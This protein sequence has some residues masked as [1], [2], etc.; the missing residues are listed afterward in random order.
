MAGGHYETSD[1]TGQP[2]LYVSAQSY[3]PEQPSHPLYDVGQP[4]PQ[5]APPYAMPTTGA[6]YPT[7]GRYPEQVPYA[8]SPPY[9][10]GEPQPQATQPVPRRKGRQVV[11]FASGIIAAM[12]IATLLV[13]G[14]VI[15]QGDGKSEPAGKKSASA[16]AGP[17]RTYRFPEE[18]CTLLELRQ[19]HALAPVTHEPGEPASRTLEG[20]TSVKCDGVFLKTPNDE[21]RTIVNA[22]AQYYQDPK[23]AQEGFA[24]HRSDCEKP[25]GG[26]EGETVPGLGQAACITYQEA[27]GSEIAVDETSLHIRDGNL[28]VIL[29]VLHGKS[30]LGKKAEIGEAIIRDAKTF[31]V[32]LA[33]V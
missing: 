25:P 8:G 10:T 11:W 4:Y 3:P 29:Q 20:Y 13:G 17:A 32:K 24:E 16:S 30:L 33:K 18:I 21:G 27:S 26:G 19:M 22:A 31:L 9:A 7:A 12:A 6:P 1:S 15:G 2:D 14:I 28:V 23:L 5:S